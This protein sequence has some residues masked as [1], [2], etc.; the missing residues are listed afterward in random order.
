VAAPAAAGVVA[1]SAGARA[2]FWVLSALL[3]CSALAIRRVPQ[4]SGRG[5]GDAEV[6]VE[7]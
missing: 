1:G 7:T 5:S 4:A 3:G 6:A 2:V